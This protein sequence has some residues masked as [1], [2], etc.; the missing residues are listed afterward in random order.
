MR[1]GSPERGVYRSGVRGQLPGICATHWVAEAQDLLASFRRCDSTANPMAS[2]AWRR[3]TKGLPSTRVATISRSVEAQS[4]CVRAQCWDGGAMNHEGCVAEGSEL[5][6]AITNVRGW[7]LVLAKFNEDDAAEQHVLAE[8]GNCP[9][10]LYG[11][12]QHALGFGV[13]RRRGDGA[14]E[15]AEY[16]LSEAISRRDDLM[17]G[18]A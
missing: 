3:D 10:C 5:A 6:T 4:V 7:R 11:L 15:K 13:G 18:N 17:R 8:I 16:M 12:L 2:Q 9:E 1:N 14:V